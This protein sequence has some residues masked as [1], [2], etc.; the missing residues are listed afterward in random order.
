MCPYVRPVVPGAV[1][2]ATANNCCAAAGGGTV[3]P[4]AP[5]DGF[6]RSFDVDDERAPAAGA[7]YGCAGLQTTK[8]RR[9][10]GSRVPLSEERKLFNL[11]TDPKGTV[12]TRH[13]EPA[14]FL[15]RF[16]DIENGPVDGLV[17]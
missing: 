7:P 13:G 15:V 11:S 8:K 9:S 5:D 6:M 1:G 14:P 3:N 2:G 10:T 12:F 16:A 4:P 17:S